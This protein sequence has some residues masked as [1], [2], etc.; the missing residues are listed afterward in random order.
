MKYLH[1]N[2]VIQIVK[3]VKEIQILVHHVVDNCNYKILPVK[4]D[5]IKVSIN[6]RINVININICLNKLPLLQLV[7]TQL[8]I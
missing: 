1:V 3:L 7:A 6:I 5:V 2:N 8:Y 4:K